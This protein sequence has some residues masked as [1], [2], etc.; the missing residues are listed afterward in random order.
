M[1][2]L[3]FDVLSCDENDKHS[4]IYAFGEWLNWRI[5]R[6]VEAIIATTELYVHYIKKADVHF[7]GYEDNFIQLMNR[8]FSEAEEMEGSDNS[9]MLNRVVKIQDQ[10]LSVGLNS[11][12][13]WLKAAERP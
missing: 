3:F 8:L 12:N 2:R 6:N 4:R 1:I 5:Q 10:L 11:I 13:D 9:A 7:Y